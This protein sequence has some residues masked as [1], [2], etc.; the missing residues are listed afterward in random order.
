MIRS[1]SRF[2]LFPAAL[3]G[4]G[5][6]FFVARGLKSAKNSGLVAARRQRIQP[7]SSH[8]ATARAALPIVSDAKANGFQ[9]ALPGYR[10]VFP[11]DH[12]S[13]P[14]FATEWWY[15]T[16]H[17]Q[18]RAGRTFGYQLTFFR[19]A[20]APRLPVRSSK[21][22][23]RDI[24]FA[25]LALTDE[26]QG[27][28]F[29]T[30]R[31]AR[32]ALQIAGAE[33]TVPHVWIGDWTLR[34][35]LKNQTL[36]AQGRM[37]TSGSQNNVAPRMST[38]V[39]LDLVQSALKP[40]I[41][42][43]QNGVSQKSAGRGRASHYY[44]FTRLQTKGTLK[45]DDETF[46]VE[47][48]SWFDHEFGSNQLAPDQVGWDWF[49]LQLNDGRE[50]MLYRMRLKNGATDPYS[51]GTIIDK[52]GLTRHLANRDF[53]IGKQAT[54][55]SAEGAQYPARWRLS[56]PR[57][58]LELEV[59]PTVSDQELHTGGVSGITYW[60][61]SARVRGT[62]RGQALNGQAYVELTGYD[63]AFGSTF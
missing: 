51:S 39:A 44:S 28:F 48:Q 14:A 7:T 29:F 10:Y 35:N 21:W 33:T 58:G 63:K 27:R 6:M 37:Q 8:D 47:G 2:W 42:H 25:H 54:W 30:D 38:H 55:R 1:R 53:T 59:E 26:T 20:L 50:L 23:T 24:I 41:V 12:A 9:L 60:E 36:R 5:L 19:Q 62:Q 46:A 3:A 40:P 4:S 56:V 17:L 34:F 11:R 32:A 18:S 57:E 13:H 49:S 22:A 61:G 15:Y 43:G 31:I 45:L 52:N 16:G